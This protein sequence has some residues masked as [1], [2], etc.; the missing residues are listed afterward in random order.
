MALS[1]KRK[2]EIK[3][4]SLSLHLS[5][6]VNGIDVSKNENI[7]PI[8]EQT[9]PPDQHDLYNKFLRCV[10]IN[11]QLF[12]MVFHYQHFLIYRNED[13]FNC[14]L[15]MDTAILCGVDIACIAI[16]DPGHISIPVDQA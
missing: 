5:L 9:T 15:V 4:T 1:N 14:R 10:R 7:E 2:D 13:R 8:K 3:A 6:A 16:L 11:Y 12:W